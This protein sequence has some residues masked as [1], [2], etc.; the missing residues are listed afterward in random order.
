[1]KESLDM[2]LMAGKCLL[3]VFSENLQLSS[4]FLDCLPPRSNL[5]FEVLIE[6]SS[7]S[8]DEKKFSLHLPNSV[9]LC[10]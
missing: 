1:M 4:W 5:H 2:E 10:L 9:L 3:S 7:P 6:L 8:M